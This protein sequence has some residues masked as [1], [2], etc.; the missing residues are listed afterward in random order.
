MKNMQKLVPIVEF[1]PV[2]KV[3]LMEVLKERNAA[4]SYLRIDVSASSGGCGCS[5]GQKYVM[6]L[7]QQARPSD[8]IEE[9]DSIKVVTDKNNAEVLRGSKIDYMENFQM[10]GFKIENPNI[11]QDQGCGCGGH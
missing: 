10:S 6:E 3:K 5:G 11:Q 1:T 7:A 8:L 4:D 2:A 9:V